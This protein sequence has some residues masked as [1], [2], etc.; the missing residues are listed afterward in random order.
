MPKT[1]KTCTTRQNKTYEPYPKR[2]SNSMM[3]KTL[4]LF[5]KTFGAPWYFPFQWLF[6]TNKKQIQTVNTPT[7]II[8][9]TDQ[10]KEEPGS[11]VVEEENTECTAIA[12]ATEPNV[13]EESIDDMSTTPAN[14]VKVPQSTVMVNE[15]TLDH[16]EMSLQNIEALLRSIPDSVLEY[17]IKDVENVEDVE[18]VSIPTDIKKHESFDDELLRDS[19]SHNHSVSQNKNIYNLRNNQHLCASVSA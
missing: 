12:L 6:N 11:I 9:P 7:S 1:I 17:A 18:N 19:T 5:G 3:R 15:D 2:S 13:V 16:E 4:S 14:I 8:S 10:T